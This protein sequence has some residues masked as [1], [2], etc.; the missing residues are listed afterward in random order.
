MLKINTILSL[1]IGIFLIST[2][3]DSN[4]AGEGRLRV[5]LTDSPA[6]YEA[7]TIN[8][9]R[10]E[11]KSSSD[12]SNSGWANL[13]DTPI[14]INLLSLVNGIDTVLGEIPLKAGKYEQIR[15]ILGSGNTVTIDGI[16]HELDTPSAQ[17][18]GLKLKMNTEIEDGVTYS[19]VMDFDASKSIVKTGN[20]NNPKYILKPVIRLITE[21]TSGSIGGFVNPISAASSV[22]AVSGEDTLGTYANTL[23]GGFLIRGVM[24]GTHAVT[25]LSKDAA[26]RDSTISNVTVQIGQ[27]TDLGTVNLHVS[28]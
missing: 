20:P 17:Q 2:C 24:I 5:S 10:V 19:I 27:K 13:M 26:Y 14:T 3:S 7:V 4:N 1:V 6:L 28:N 9:Q 18:S 21:A 12:S 11:I 23:S 8:V 15:L 25:I 22:F 16:D